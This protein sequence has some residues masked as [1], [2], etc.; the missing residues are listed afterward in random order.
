MPD[1]LILLVGPDAERAL[2]DLRSN[3]EYDKLD[4]RVSVIETEGHMEGDEP[5]DP[6]RQ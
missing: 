5:P 2:N 1:I 3:V 6:G 4:V